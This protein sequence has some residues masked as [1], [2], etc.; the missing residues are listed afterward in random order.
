[1]AI[2]LFVFIR[3]W[4]SSLLGLLIGLMLG[5]YSMLIPCAIYFILMVK[6]TC[7]LATRNNYNKA[8]L[9]KGVYDCR[10]VFT[11]DLL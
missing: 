2:L 8:M 9:C 5:H 6:R 1:M 11:L 4:N 7:V 3:V 10:T